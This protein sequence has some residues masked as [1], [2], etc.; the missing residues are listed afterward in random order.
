MKCA[1]VRNSYGKSAVRLSKVSR[2][3]QTHTIQEYCVEIELEGDFDKS[4]T[5]GDNSTIVAT[6]SM[7][8]TVYILAAENEFTCPEQFGKLLAK[9]FV[10]QYAQVDAATIR[11]TEAIWQRIEHEGRPHEHAFVGGSNE[12]RKTKVSL[13]S[14]Q[15]KVESAIEA[16][17]VLKTT[18]SG[19]V[20]FVRDK[21]TTLPETTDR[22]FATNIDCT[23][24]Y[25]DSECDFNQTYALVREEILRTFCNH[26]SLGVQQT[27]QAMGEAVL[28]AC[29]HILE[30]DFTMPN[31]HRIPFD[32]SR[33]NME[34]RN[35]IFVTTSEPFGV[36]KGRIR[37]TNAQQDQR[38][39][40]AGACN[41]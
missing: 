17:S 26:N 31:Q 36:I 24:T 3:G 29:P 20:G 16:L 8:N 7:K 37:R 5:A 2:N 33:F 39:L 30:I 1:L 22:V 34:N 21:Y 28:V 4:Y 15:L 35:E 19:F 25:C 11:I 13:D 6:D 12:R 27:L 41:S 18:N 38:Q 10:S 9:H 32:L 14:S 40:T 23:W